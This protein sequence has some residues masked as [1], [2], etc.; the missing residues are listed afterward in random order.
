M[1]ELQQRDAEPSLIEPSLTTALGEE[2]A[3]ADSLAGDRAQPRPRKRDRLT[4][5][6][7]L[8]GPQP[9]AA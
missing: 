5:E 4:A 6:K 8:D 3:L 9:A 1:S 7:L 2:M